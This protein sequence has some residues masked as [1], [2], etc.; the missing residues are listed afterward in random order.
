VVTAVYNER[1]LLS[2][3][4][5][6]TVETLESAV[7]SFELII[8][9]DG[10]SDDSFRSI[11]KLSARDDRVRG[12]RFPR[13]FGHHVALTAG[14]DRATGDSIAIMDSDLQDP[15]EA[16]PDLIAKLEEGFDIVA[17]ERQNKKFSLGKRLTGALFEWLMRRTFKRDYVGGNF[18]VFRRKVLRE[19][20]KC[21][22]SERLLVGLIE[23]TGF[24]QTTVPVE[25]RDRPAGESS[26]SIGK[27]IQ[28]AFDSLT[29]FSL[30]PLRLTSLAGIG[31]SIVGFLAMSYLIFRK[32]VFGLGLPGWSS[33]MVTIIFIGGIQLLSLGVLGEYIGRIFTAT[34]NRPLY[35]V[36]E[37]VGITE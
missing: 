4:Y 13:N 23:W 17:A 21:R 19:V 33:L 11:R 32:L 34:R 26:Y 22:E 20:R 12:L 8:V 5:E 18:R 1:E 30:V 2:E 35:I 25:H 28:L 3:F 24:E 10:S 31:F 37:T 14:L 29:S 36:D 6:R 15:P 9:D 27:Q 7:D 16:L